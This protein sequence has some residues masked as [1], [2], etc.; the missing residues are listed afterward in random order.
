MGTT[1]AFLLAFIVFTSI[2]EARRGSS[3]DDPAYIASIKQGLR[4]IRCPCSNASLCE[5]LQNTPEKELIGFSA[6]V[7]ASVYHNFD[8][9]QVSS[10]TLYFAKPSFSE[11]AS[12]H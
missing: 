10:G 8:W 7:P 6:N 9:S 1:L 4:G 5:P 2:A 3:V 11:L 12:S